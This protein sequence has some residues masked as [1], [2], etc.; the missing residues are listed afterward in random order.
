MYRAELINDFERMNVTFNDHT[1]YNSP[2][3]C[4]HQDPELMKKWMKKSQELRKTKLYSWFNESVDKEK[5]TYDNGDIDSWYETL[6]LDKEN[7]D[8][9]S[10]VSSSS[11][12]DP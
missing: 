12:P 10:I 6:I 3:I 9:L 2:Y 4:F 1:F 7:K 11:A 8:S 5:I